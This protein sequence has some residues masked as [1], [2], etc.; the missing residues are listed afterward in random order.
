MCA[1]VGEDCH[2]TWESV[3]L[4][5]IPVVRES[6]IREIFSDAPV[7][8]LRDWE[9]PKADESL[10]LNRRV[11]GPSFAGRRNIM[12]QYWFD[13]IAAIRD[14]ELKRAPQEEGGA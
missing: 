9:S 8:V 1:G 4:G 12:A 13:R 10:F 3:L 5:A 2:R 7:F 6:L 14:R 11:R